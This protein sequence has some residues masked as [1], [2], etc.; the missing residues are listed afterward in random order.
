VARAFKPSFTAGTSND[1]AGSYS[2]F[3]LA[4]SR[5]DSEQEFEDLETTLPPGLLAK[6][7]GVRLCG[8]TEA[9]T[10][11]C[12]AESQIGTVT[13]T[14]GV[15]PDPVSVPGSVYLT[16]PYNGGPFGESVEIPAIAGPF[17]LDENNEP[18]VVR[19]SIRINPTTGQ[20]T[21]LSDPFPTKLRGIPLHE[22]AVSVTLNRPEFAFNPT[23]CQ[24]LQT[25]ATITS[26]TAA[27]ANVSSPFEAAN[28]ANL[29][30]TPKLTASTGHQA[31]KADG[32]NLNVT[33]TSTGVG[34]ANIAKVF[35][36][37][38]KI[39]PTRLT[40]LQKAC[41]AAVF[42]A[43]PAA[44]DEGSVIGTATIHTPIL[45]SPLSGPAYLV[46]HGGAAFPD[47]EFVLQ[48]E[49]VE[50]VLDGKTDIKNGVTYSRF[51]STPD[52]PFTSFETELPAGPHSILTAN[53]DIVPDYDL[54]GQ[55]I[56]I[57]TEITGQNGALIKQTTKVTVTGCPKAKTPTKAQLLAKALKACKKD[58]R[59]S[60]RLACEKKARKK[61][62]ANA[63]KTTSSKT[64]PHKK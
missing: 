30:F 27:T 31:S 64:K 22:R 9:D 54:C 37:I 11:S 46:S 3:T 35:L 12:P 44:C 25:N 17:N 5:S 18:V 41:P 38:P 20:A 42:E 53:N 2:P 23:N 32:E 14:A 39:L 36:T 43:N 63:T 47:V 59:K 55:N 24:R 15:G 34:Q 52:A 28:C 62:P 50:I 57:P 58:K 29:P 51:E 45:G 4:L 49:G 6:L 10:G 16:G 26:T 19:G 48:G 7:A 8:N 61:Y 21:V 40:T 60:K 56:T 13:A 1:Q 33:V